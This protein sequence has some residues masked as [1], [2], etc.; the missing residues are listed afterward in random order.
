MR[1]LL[2]IA[3]L[4]FAGL[5]Q[6]ADR[7]L[8]VE[9]ADPFIELHTGPG[10]GYPIF[11][12]VERGESVLILKQRTD[13]FKVR[14]DRDHEGWVNRD[15]MV[16]TL[17]PGGEQVELKSASL[18][19][20]S[21][22]RWETGVLA[23]DFGGA[24]VLSTYGAFAFT[25]NLSAELSV[26]QVLGNF[27]DGQLANLSVVFRFLPEWRTSPFFTLGTGVIHTEPKATIVQPEDRTDQMAHAGLGVQT[28]LTRRFVFRAEYKRYVVFTSRDDNEEINEWKA[29]FSFFF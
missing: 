11:H 18:R 21:T 28:Y 24:N 17:Y 29:G 7:H 27:S 9:V 13:W 20:Y 6:A 26:S 25:S 22:R 16:K 10:V 5:A 4:L 19:D 14:T 23:G 1:G 15:Q 2:L 12:V 8:I 3:L